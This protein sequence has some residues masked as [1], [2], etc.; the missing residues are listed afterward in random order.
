MRSLP[1]MIALGALALAAGL[2]PARAAPPAACKVGWSSVSRIVYGDES[3]SAVV[4]RGRYAG[5]AD[6]AFTVM[7]DDGVLTLALL[8]S[9]WQSDGRAAAN[10]TGPV[11]LRKAELELAEQAA[12]IGTAY[13][14]SL[15]RS[16]GGDET[17][18][19]EY[20]ERQEI[21]RRLAAELRRLSARAGTAG[22]NVPAGFIRDRI[23]VFLE[24]FMPGA[25]NRLEVYYVD[26]AAPTVAN[27][28]CDPKAP[29]ALVGQLIC[30]R[31]FA[32]GAARPVAA[33][34]GG[35]VFE[36]L[37]A[38]PVCGQTGEDGGAPD[39]ACGP[40]KQKPAG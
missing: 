7:D 23:G 10:L 38:A 17:D 26:P 35:V 31:N 1:T 16:G 9:Q 6:S 14:A 20:E 22:V 12:R 25:P 34:P 28:F 15:L 2:A 30:G 32:T 27:P 5:P 4:Y 19:A 3:L 36:D 29:N 37:S 24:R 21:M 8:V 40:A 18:R 13:Q 11:R 33:C 39:P